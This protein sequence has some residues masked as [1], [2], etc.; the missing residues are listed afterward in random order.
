MNPF[1]SPARP[2]P[3][4]RTSPTDGTPPSAAPAAGAARTARVAGSFAVLLLVDY[5]AAG[6][7]WGWARMVLGQRP[8]RGVPGLRFAKVLGS[9]HEGGFGLR[10][11]GSRQGLFCVFVDEA[12]A[13]A[14]AADS[15]VVAAYRAHARECCIALLRATSCKGA[16]DGA[17]LQPAGELPA[18]GPV[19]A[20][21]RASIRPRR[22]AAFWRQSP[23]S[24]ASLAA[25]PGCRLSVGLGEAPLLRQCTVSLW[26]SV[27]AMDAY[28]RS[29]A[30]LQAI[31]TAY[32]GDF[33][34]ESMFVRFALLSLQGR[35]KG[36]EHGL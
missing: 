30:H 3:L 34:A 28:A 33:F 2:A 7:P 14:F 18:G 27:A 23:P 17:A 21:T 6:R 16:W 24:E 12:A 13:R 8:L 32:A 22:L 15:P 10:P 31:R 26:D 20:L 5:C 36:R 4:E 1:A 11:S 29:G 35:W 19:V 9:G 25:A